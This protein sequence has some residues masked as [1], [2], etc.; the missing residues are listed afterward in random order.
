VVSTPARLFAQLQAPYPPAGPIGVV[1]QSG[2]F[3]MASMNYAIAAGIGVSRA[4]SA[5]NALAVG[6]DEY[7]A[8]FAED[9]TTTVSLAYVEGLA[10]GRR[11]YQRLRRAT[12]AKPVVLVHGGTT[13]AGARAARSHT[14]ALASD[15]RVFAGMCRQAGIT[16]AATVEEGFEAAATFATQPLPRG[17]RTVVL[18]L[19]G[20][21]GVLA[22]DAMA[23]TELELASLPESLKADIDT[24]VPP[25]WSRQ[26]PIDLAGGETRDTVTE[27]LELA[28]AHPDVDAVIFV[29]FG[30]QSNTAK[31]I[32]TSP[33]YPEHG[34]DRIVAY[35]ERQDSRYARAA[36]EASE[37]HGKPVLCV[38]ELAV[39]DPSNGAPA[40][41][42][43]TGRLCYPSVNRA[44]TALD[45]LWR[46]ERYRRRQGEERADF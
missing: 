29:G 5:G 22:A 46:Y 25:R 19:A 38:T 31:L 2:N 6:V 9:P 10:D 34:L 7:L 36:A 30:I 21:W 3:V 13:T 16:L 18:T 26:N 15:Q 8:W 20:G 43:A 45:H 27:V 33:H 32:R 44:V 35:H 24:R 12:A 41:V 40:T 37:R 14:G 42:R 4:V 1:S 23:E 39:T 11:F 17:P 28:T